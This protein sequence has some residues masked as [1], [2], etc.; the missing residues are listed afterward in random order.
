MKPKLLIVDDDIAITRQLYWALFDY[1][2][3]TTA[4][5]QRTALRRLSVY[6]P[7]VTILD[8]QLSDITDSTDSGM[9]VLEFIKS[10][11]PQMKVV[12][13]SS[14]I[15][16]EIRLQCLDRGAD[17]VFAKPFSTEDLISSLLR[18]LTP[19]ANAVGV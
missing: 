3:V 1:F 4:N 16:E 5:D 12:I 9:E 19:P 15:D 8:L 11:L 2:D 13:L 14:S 7:A 10:R 18:Q 17:D 6:E